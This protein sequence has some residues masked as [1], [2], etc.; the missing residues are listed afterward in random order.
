[1]YLNDAY[2]QDGDLK[3]WLDIFM[4]TC[5]HHNT[6]VQ[7]P[8][9]CTVFFLQH[10]LTYSIKFRMGTAGIVISLICFDF[11]TI[12]FTCLFIYLFFSFIV[13]CT[14]Y[15]S[16]SYKLI[17]EIQFNQFNSNVY[18]FCDHL[19]LVRVWINKLLT[20]LIFI[21]QKPL[22]LHGH[23]RSITQIKY[24][25]D[26]DLLFSS[27]KD[28]QPNVWYAINGERLGTYKGHTGAVWCLDINCILF[29]IWK[30]LIW[31]GFEFMMNQ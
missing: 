5:L 13:T 7:K 30:C 29:Q 27:A 24:N 14:C 21:F 18:L 3:L 10:R 15:L 22:M 28:P 16:G 23:E 19:P 12:S 8:V 9:Y 31:M 4:F 26:G 20:Y 25:R 2:I 6:D 1:M 17:K 11:V